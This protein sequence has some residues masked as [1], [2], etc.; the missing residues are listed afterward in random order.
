MTAVSARRV[1]HADGT[2]AACNVGCVRPVIALDQLLA[3]VVGDRNFRS[4]GPLTAKHFG[5][6]EQKG[7]AR[8]S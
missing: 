2:C 7:A 6:F 4:A 3:K 5:S 8:V 1:S